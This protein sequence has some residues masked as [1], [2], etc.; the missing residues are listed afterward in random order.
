MQEVG[1]EKAGR[2]NDSSGR[3]VGGDGRK[4]VRSQVPPCLDLNLGG[5]EQGPSVTQ[6]RSR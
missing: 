4:A 3:G 2:V 1:T 6:F 5:A